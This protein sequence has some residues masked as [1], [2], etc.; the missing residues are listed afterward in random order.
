MDTFTPN[1]KGGKQTKS[2]RR[3]DKLIL[4]VHFHKS[5]GTTMISYLS[6][7]L[8]LTG[9]KTAK[10]EWLE[11]SG[12]TWAHPMTHDSLWIHS[13]NSSSTTA[14]HRTGEPGMWT[15]LYH[16]GLD[17]VS[18]ERNF[19]QPSHYRTA[20]G[21]FRAFTILRDPW[22]RFRSTYERELQL[23]CREEKEEK[24]IECLQKNTM[25]HF[26]KYSPFPRKSHGFG[27]ILYPNYYIRMLNGINDQENPPPMTRQHLETAKQILSNF[28]LVLMLEK[29]DS[30]IRQQLNLFFGKQ[31]SSKQQHSLPHRSNNGLK[32]EPMYE[33]IQNRTMRMKPAFDKQNQ[34]DIELY[35]FVKA[36]LLQVN[37]SP[38]DEDAELIAPLQN[39]TVQQHQNKASLIQPVI[40]V[41]GVLLLL[42][43]LKR[44][45]NAQ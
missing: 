27:G 24:H 13:I 17:F 2:T 11:G 33:H 5:G 35:E 8:Q 43:H 12:M 4:F 9:T 32:K 34:L 3:Y 20:S 45:N 40:L 31:A 42:C 39:T 15:Y 19:M 21:A 25:E 22:S 23:R 30:Y 26:M 36:N 16:Q 7:E 44:R 14:P 38:S 29:S 41:V 18:L 6:N 1:E 37:V 28:E 10:E